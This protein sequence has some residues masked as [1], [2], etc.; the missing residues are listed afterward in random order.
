MT[1]TT[2]AKLTRDW[3]ISHLRMG[4]VQVTFNKTDG[5]ERVMNCTLQEGVAIREEKKTDRI[6][7]VNPN[8]L[9]VYDLDANGWR[10]FRVDSVKQIAF[11]L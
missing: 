10:S 11:D 9:A 1:T 5:T 3:L 7:T 2:E 4:P 8:V 6:K